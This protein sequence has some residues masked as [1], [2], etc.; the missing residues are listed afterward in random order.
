[1]V[2]NEKVLVVGGSGV[3]GSHLIKS[4]LKKNYEVISLSKRKCRDTRVN[5]KAKYIVEDISKSI[6]KE[7]LKAIYSVDYLIYYHKF[8]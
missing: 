7:T 6:S 8:Y 2:N 1:M 5:K 3:I 4:L